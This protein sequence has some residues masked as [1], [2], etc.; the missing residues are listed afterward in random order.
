MILQATAEEILA[1]LPGPITA[2]WPTGEPFSVALRHG[3]M[4]VELFAPRDIDVQT[5]HDQDELYFVYKGAATAWIAED[6]LKI[7]A[8]SAFF[9]PAHVAHRFGDMTPDFSVWVVFWGPSG[10]EAAGVD[11]S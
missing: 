4:S 1:R 8:G 10:G 5:P 7:S 9:V 2:L 6:C 3:S 11:G